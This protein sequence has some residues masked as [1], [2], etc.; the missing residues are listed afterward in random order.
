[1]QTF[2][3]WYQTNKKRI[4]LITIP[5]ITCLVGGVYALVYMTGGIKHVFSHT[6]YIPILLAGFFFGI[7]G[8]CVV[9]LFAG[10]ILGPLMPVDTLTGEMQFAINW[11]YRTVFFM[12]IGAVNGTARDLIATYIER[13][14]WYRYHYVPSNLPNRTKLIEDLAS[15]DIGH[16]EGAVILVVI[17]IDDMME[18]EASFGYGVIDATLCQLADRLKERLPEDVVLYRIAVRELAIVTGKKES[19][20]FIGALNK[21]IP[22]MRKPVL[23]K[24][25]FLQANVMLVYTEITHLDK[26][27]EFYLRKVRIALYHAHKR[28]QTDLIIAAEEDEDFKENIELLG[29]LEQAIESEQLELYYQPKVSIATGKIDSVEA[30]I[31]WNHPSR[32]NIPPDRFI[33]RAEQSTIIEALTEWVLNQSLS[34]LADWHRKGVG[35]CLAVNISVQN[36]LQPNFPCI[37]KNILE[38]YGLDGSVLELEITEN[39]VLSNVEKV[40]V[41]LRELSSMNVGIAI[42]DFGT[43]HSSLERLHQLP[44]GTIKIDKSFVSTLLSHKGASFII[45]ASI[46]IAREFGMQV[47]AEGIDNRETYDVVAQM[48]CDIA[49]GFYIG[50]PMPARKFEEWYNASHGKFDST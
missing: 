1:M 40:K 37:V 27:P 4:E 31:R 12:I 22:V 32:G 5:V 25:L 18:E 50:R 34:Q 28:G 11:I 23:F 30:L 13:I 41:H 29:E 10:I 38:R 14:T 44:V 33:C 24:D 20:D 9:G 42:D 15:A 3:N 2:F 6:M 48:G 36:L 45:K 16:T 7:K 26:P 35:I 46:N 49:Q 21:L 43:G 47:V 17:S 8:G 39:V 19:A